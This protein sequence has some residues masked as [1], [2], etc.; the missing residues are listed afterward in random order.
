MIKVDSF[1]SLFLRPQLSINNAV[2]VYALLGGTYIDVSPPQPFLKMIQA[3][4]I[5]RHTVLA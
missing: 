4:H 5:P 3:L 1:Y 2:S